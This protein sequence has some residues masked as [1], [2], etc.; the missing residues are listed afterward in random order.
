MTNTGVK[1]MTDEQIEAVGHRWHLEV[2]QDGKTGL[3]DHILTP[4]VLTHVNGQEFRGVDAAKQLATALKTAF[5]DMQITHHEAIVSGNNVAIRWTSTQTHGGE[6]FGV[7]ASGKQIQIEGI[8][9]FHVRNGKI[10]E[11][12]IEF[13]NMGVLQQM[14]AVSQPQPAGV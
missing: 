14:G 5:P 9:L 2:V 3:A 13:D 4:D 11:M 1:T 8:D 7:P 6:Y 12:W 10:A